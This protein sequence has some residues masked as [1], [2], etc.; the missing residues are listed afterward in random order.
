MTCRLARKIQDEKR[1]ICAIEE[2]PRDAGGDITLPRAGA[3][4]H[5]TYEEPL[6]LSANKISSAVPGKTR[7]AAGPRM[8]FRRQASGA[9]R[10]LALYGA[11]QHSRSR[12]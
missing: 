11:P 1:L 9:A 4:F 8:P 2:V 3:D 12:A 10:M 6:A 7:S 5:L